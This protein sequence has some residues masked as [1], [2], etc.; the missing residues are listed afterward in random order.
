MIFGIGVSI[1]FLMDFKFLVRMDDFSP[2]IGVI[3]PRKA[4]VVTLS[5]LATFTYLQISQQILRQSA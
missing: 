2:G 4:S 1:H 5:C 3:D